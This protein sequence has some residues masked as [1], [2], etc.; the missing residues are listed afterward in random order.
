MN[1]L[2][3]FRLRPS[4][5]ATLTALLVVPLTLL[6]ASTALAQ[7]LGARRGAILEQLDLSPEQ[8]E[9]FQQLRQSRRTESEAKRTELLAEQSTL[10]KLLAGTASE[11]QI[12]TQFERVQSLRHE[13]GQQ[14]FESILAIRQVLTPEQRQE[15]AAELGD[16]GCRNGVRSLCR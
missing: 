6:P 14:Q 10:R 13:F 2:S 9:Q 3:L 8:I 11:Q 5:A 15:L 1:P 12:R 4:T 7:P 16:R